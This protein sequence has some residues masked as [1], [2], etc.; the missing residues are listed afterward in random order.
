MKKEIVGAACALAAAVAAIA[1]FPAHAAAG[2]EMSEDGKHWMYY[3]DWDE[4]MTDTWI[5]LEGKTYYLDTKGYMKTG[6]VTDKESGNKYYMG[7]DGAM[8][9]NMFA[10]NGSYVGHDGAQVASYD[11]YRKAVKSEVS[12][13][14]KKS[15]KAGKKKSGGAQNSFGSSGSPA[16]TGGVQTQSYFALTDLNQD[17]YRDLVVMEGPAEAAGGFFGSAG[18]MYPAVGV[19]NGYTGA[20]GAGAGNVYTGTAG[21]GAADVQTASDTAWSLGGRLLEVAVWSPEEERF[22]LSAEFDSS[23]TEQHSTLYRDP[24]GGG[25]WL[26]IADRNG[27]LRFFQ[28][29]YDS[30]VFENVW[31][32]TMDLDDWG[33]AVYRMNVDEEDRSV[34]EQF[35]A[36]ARSRRGNTP[37]TGYLPATDDNLA[38]Q[39]DLLLTEEE[40]KMW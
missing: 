25:V 2:W 35:I 6:W 10:P 12:K 4:P 24:D 14:A 30:T 21:V 33:G 16:G 26:E 32:F 27:D 9:Y 5:E 31:S 37:V 34:W 38:A 23:D 36:Q 3:D 18:S 15:G 11:K 40:G 20:A 8:C 19:G 29:E 13:A 22:Q 7:E 39:V 28:M 1:S 17:G